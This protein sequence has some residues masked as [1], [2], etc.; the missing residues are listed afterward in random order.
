MLKD[1]IQWI[2][3]VLRL[4]RQ[5][6]DVLLDI[7]LSEK[8]QSAI[9]LWTMLYKGETPYAEAGETVR[10]LRLPKVL[11][12]ELARMVT[13]ELRTELHGSER[14]EFLNDT[15]QKLIETVRPHVEN[16]CA[17]G[18]I[19]FKPYVS[20]GKVVV[21]CVGAERF[22]PSDHDSS[23]KICGGAFISHIV[24]GGKIYTRIEW[25]Y[26]TD[27]TYHVQNMAY[28][29]DNKESRGR[30]I[31]LS[32]VPEWADIEPH[33]TVQGLSRP[34]FSYFRMPFA[35]KIDPNSP[36]GVS[37]FA[38]AVELIEDADR[39]YSRLL[40]EFEGG[41]LAIDADVDALRYDKK[42][43]NGRLA[44]GRGRLFRRLDIPQ[45]DKG[46]YEV[47]S[48][49]LRDNSLTN[50]LNEILIHIEDA[51]GFARGTISKL[52]GTTEKTAEEIKSAKQRTYALVSDV[53]KA[54]QH[55]L[56]ELVEAMD[57]LCD[58]YS[59]CPK[60]A[61]DVSFEFDDSVVCDRKSE[62]AEKLQLL[63]AGIMQPYAF[64]MWYFGEDEETAKAAVQ[65]DMLYE[66]DL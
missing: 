45:G 39:Q 12:D 20:D 58:L 31:A 65:K 48:P 46:L 50:G 10:S 22:L 54:L 21:D 37:V 5:E 14:A 30:S 36:A 53:Q 64:R 32:A 27:D 49:S 4:W 2:L 38:D 61:V 60:G 13:I 24:R 42:N 3:D 63:S 9:D 51:C 7:Q 17:K 55:A 1:L 44:S 52:T 66:D 29:S 15:Y 41:E 59:L 23:G 43:P 56:E 8:M 26:F 16:A 6:D 35:N 18:G 62:F 25:H 11:A 34:L 33:T 19:V 40:W 47:F 28:V 57:A